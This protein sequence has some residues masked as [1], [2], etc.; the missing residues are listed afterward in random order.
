VRESYTDLGG[1]VTQ[2]TRSGLGRCWET[3]LLRDLTYIGG[4]LLVL[5]GII[6]V[7]DLSVGVTIYSLAE[8]IGGFLLLLLIGYFVGMV[9]QKGMAMIGI[10]RTR[11]RLIPDAKSW[12]G[13]RAL[14]A[15]ISQKHGDALVWDFEEALLKAHAAATLGA[16]A[17]VSTVIWLINFIAHIARSGELDSY[18]IIYLVLFV[19]LFVGF[20]ICVRESSFRSR[21]AAAVLEELKHLSA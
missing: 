18:A 12:A 20:L 10:L 21:Q 3:F 4:G 19:L 14:L 15:R 17:L 13:T 11:T 1:H 8:S 6:R 7:V 16:C 9:V 5:L 2:E